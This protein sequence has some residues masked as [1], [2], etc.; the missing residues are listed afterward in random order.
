M[1]KYLPRYFFVRYYGQVAEGKNF[2]EVIS[3]LILKYTV[4][5]PSAASLYKF[6]P[7]RNFMMTKELLILVRDTC[8]CTKAILG[9]SEMQDTQCA[10]KA[11][12]ICLVVLKILSF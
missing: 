4:M 6:I 1:Q 11:K 2:L 5:H 7:H 10:A 9:F 12:G 3:N 8:I